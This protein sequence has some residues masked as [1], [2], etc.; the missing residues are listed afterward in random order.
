[1]KIIANIISTGQNKN[2]SNFTHSVRIILCYPTIMYE[3]SL[4][5][6]NLFWIF[7]HF[8]WIILFFFSLCWL[9]FCS[10][11]CTF[12]R[13]QKNLES[14]S[15]LESFEM[16]IKSLNNNKL[17]FETKN[18]SWLTSEKG[19]WGICR[20]NEGSF[21]FPLK[22]SFMLAKRMLVLVQFAKDE[23]L[24]HLQSWK[25]E[26][27]FVCFFEHKKK[28]FRH[29]TLRNMLYWKYLSSELIRTIR[30]RF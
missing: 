30:G 11:V 19:N 9:I 21:N 14:K 23:E 20:V 5:D 1:M 16:Q 22:N 10:I 24:F 18:I 26:H 17:W 25:K 8:L 4:K 13:F 12:W 27:N 7:C 29:N 2:Y 28:I 6:Y 3:A 15:I